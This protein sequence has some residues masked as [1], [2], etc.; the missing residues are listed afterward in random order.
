MNRRRFLPLLAAGCLAQEQ[1]QEWVCPMDPDVRSKS[2]GFCPRCGMK[3]V[4]ANA[5]ISEYPLRVQVTPSDWRGG[6]K[7][8]LRFEILNPKTGA[9]VQRLQLVHE[10][11]FHLFIVSGDLTYFAHEHPQPQSDGTFTFE[12]VLPKQGYYRLAADFYPEGG[13]PQLVVKTLISADAPLEPME[14]PRLQADTGAKQC[15]NLTVSLTTEPAVPLAGLKTILFFDLHPANRLEPYLGVWGHLLVA[16]ADLIDLIHLHP[17]LA[18]GAKGK[19]QFNLVFPRPGMYRLWVQF[20][21][22]SL[23]NTAVFTIPVRELD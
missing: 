19:I 4:P 6:Q 21:R 15:V 10:K 1:Q 8:S 5:E 2:P 18:D 20:Q 9:R 11:L 13:T 7:V 17:F 3:L 22:D 14:P 16:S 23:V 12:T